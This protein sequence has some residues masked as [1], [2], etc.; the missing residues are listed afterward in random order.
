MWRST[1]RSDVSAGV[2]RQREDHRGL[3]A[4]EPPPGLYVV[5]GSATEPAWSA[6]VPRK[7]VHSVVC[8]ARQSRIRH[9]LDPHVRC[10]RERGRK[11]APQPPAHSTVMDATNRPRSRSSRNAPSSSDIAGS[12]AN[13]H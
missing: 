5:E 1:T 12:S 10:E 13:P 11:L 8:L 4:S 6:Y 9:R 3:G 7:S 2:G